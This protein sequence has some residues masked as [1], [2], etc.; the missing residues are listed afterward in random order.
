MPIC[1]GCG[2]EKPVADFY[3]SKITLSGING[4]CK[5]C[6]SA[7]S[8]ITKAANTEHYRAYEKSRALSPDRVA[9][10][11]EYAKTE[12]GAAAHTRAK[13][14]YMVKHPLRR[15][16]NN[17]VANAVRDGRLVR[18]P[19]IICGHSVVHGHHPDYSRPLDVVWLCVTH[20]N[21]THL[22]LD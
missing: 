8:K 14:A 3:V 11:A 5:V 17:A 7:Q 9:L 12:K 18:L 22:M 13:T 1:K 19:C 21:E 4:K 20:H 15:A 6:M 10:R 2:Q 16:A